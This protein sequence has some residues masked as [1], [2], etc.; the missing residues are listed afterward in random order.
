M[1]AN[2]F[3]IGSGVAEDTSIVFD[4]NAQDFY[5]ALDDSADDL[6]IG[7]G[8]TI[9]TTPIMSFDENKDV[10]I[11]DGG[12]TITT[13]DNTDTLTLIS[14][15]TDSAIG[16]NLNLYR[17]AGNGA[18]A[19]NLAT[20]AF[21]GNDDAGNAT[22]FYRITAQIED[23]SNGSEDVYVHHRSMVA[24]TEQLRMSLYQAE[25]VFND[26]SADIDFRVESNDGTHALFVDAGNNVVIV[27]GIDGSGT[28][29]VPTDTNLSLIHI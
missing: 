21:A 3:T 24:G 15:D 13:A 9:G 11:H 29:P 10:V 19:D 12:L 18:D 23:A 2:T 6:V 17:N 8:N 14:T 5:V 25:A 16:P 4:G 20:V 7:L 1:T 28:T 26:G 22:D 27:G